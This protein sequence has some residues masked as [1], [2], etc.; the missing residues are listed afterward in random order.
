MIVKDESHIIERSLRSVRD[1]IDYW[2]IVD[3]GSTDDT[4]EKIKAF[5]ADIP[6]ELH[7]RPWKNFR[8]NRNEALDLAREHGDYLLFTDA[9]FVWVPEQNFKLPELTADAY[10]VKLYASSK[11]SSWKLKM[12]AS[13]K[14]PWHYYGEGGSHAVL[15]SD[16]PFTLETLTGVYIH[17]QGGGKRRSSKNA[18]AK[19]EHDIE[20]FKKALDKNPGDPRATFYLA[21]SYRDAGDL[22][23]AI[24]W[25][26]KRAEL[27]H[28]PEEAWFSRLQ[29][30]ILKQTLNHPWEEVERAYLDAYEAAPMR[31][32][33]LYPICEH[34]RKTQAFDQ[35]Y[36]IAKKAIAIPHPREAVLYV[37]ESIYD[38][39][40]LYEYAVAAYGVG[41]YDEAARSFERLLAEDKLP[42]MQRPR[43]QQNLAHS[44]ASALKKRP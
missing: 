3:T 23:T 39:R 28:D 26:A 2:V 19:Y 6:G 42:D 25:F 11:S 31:A 36:P 33:P 30:G 12:L 34:Y 8:H 4:K 21:Q 15:H 14:K 22:P 27:C 9:S 32:E 16:E 37:E 10:H 1:F 43:V 17:A 41:Q 38:W 44:R 40:M 18:T 7:E 5:L 20:K 24:E 29:I 35:S 13:A